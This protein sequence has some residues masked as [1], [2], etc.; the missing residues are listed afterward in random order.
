MRNWELGTG[1]DAELEA[2]WAPPHRPWELRG[3]VH[4]PLQRR[5]RNPRRVRDPAAGVARIVALRNR[6]S[7]AYHIHYIRCLCL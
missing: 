3:V 7:T 2:M 5:L 6:S 4:R 1:N